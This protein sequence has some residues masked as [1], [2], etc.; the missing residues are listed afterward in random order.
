MLGASFFFLFTYVNHHTQGR[1]ALSSD[2]ER[3][4]RQI[5]AA[6]LDF[7]ELANVSQDKYEAYWFIRLATPDRERDKALIATPVSNERRVRGC[8]K[9]AP[10]R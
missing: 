6:G 5:K 7:V 1:N 10:P 4:A 2:P 3:F 8:R 9:F